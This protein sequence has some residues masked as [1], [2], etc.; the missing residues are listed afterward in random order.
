MISRFPP[1]CS[2]RIPAGTGTVSVPLGPC[3]FSCSPIETFTPEGTGIGFFPT[4]DMS[5]RTLICLALLPNPA[6]NFA[7]DALLARRPARHHTLRR[8]QNADAKTAL[9]LRNLIFAG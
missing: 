4:L 3:T 8:G 7:A 6:Q 5:Y 2:T 9:H 1:F